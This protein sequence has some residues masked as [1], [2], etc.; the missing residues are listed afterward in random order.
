MTR[1]TVLSVVTPKGNLCC[2]RLSPE[3][4][5]G[6]SSSARFNYEYWPIDGKTPPIEETFG[7][8][9]HEFKDVSLMFKI[10]M[11]DIAYL[12]DLWEQQKEE[13]TQMGTRIHTLSSGW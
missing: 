12:D 13:S 2:I 1:N 9:E 4:Y 6:Y 5:L 10:L 11:S 7:F 8:A 3:Q